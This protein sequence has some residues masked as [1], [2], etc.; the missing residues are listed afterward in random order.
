MDHLELFQPSVCRLIT[1]KSGHLKVLEGTFLRQSLTSRFVVVSIILM[2]LKA[3][4]RSTRTHMLQI[5][6][7]QLSCISKIRLNKTQ[8]LSQKLLNGE[9]RASHT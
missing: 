6:L 1:N 4:V 7:T 3:A 8:I 9:V 2:Y 5:L